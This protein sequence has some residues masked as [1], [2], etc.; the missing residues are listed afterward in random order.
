MAVT[1]GALQG[2]DRLAYAPLAPLLTLIPFA[3]LRR[4]RDFEDHTP[5]RTRQKQEP[6]T[7]R[8]AVS[9]RYSAGRAKDRRYEGD[10]I[11]TVFRYRVRVP[12]HVRI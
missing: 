12:R 11:W 1:R 8:L 9:V 7:A 5:S 2:R 10:L 3:S 6:L 4:I